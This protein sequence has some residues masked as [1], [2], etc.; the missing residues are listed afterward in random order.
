[1]ILEVGF[2][3]DVDGEIVQI[4]RLLLGLL[5]VLLRH[6]PLYFDDFGV[7]GGR[8]AGAGLCAAASD[9]LLNH[10]LVRRPV[11]LLSSTGADGTLIN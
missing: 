7:L 1:L 5:L 4:A 10:Q 8:V 9:F 3:E 11:S 6:N 2:V